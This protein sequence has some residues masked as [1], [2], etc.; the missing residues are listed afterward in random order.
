MLRVLTLDKQNHNY[1]AQVMP[2]AGQ[3]FVS[4]LFISPGNGHHVQSPSRAH[5]HSDTSPCHLLLLGAGAAAGPHGQVGTAP[6]HSS[7][8]FSTPS[9]LS[10]VRSEVPVPLHMEKVIFKLSGP[11]ITAYISTE[12]HGDLQVLNR[13]RLGCSTMSSTMG[14]ASSQHNMRSHQLSGDTHSLST[15]KAFLGTG[16]PKTQ[17]SFHLMTDTNLNLQPQVIFFPPIIIFLC[18]EGSTQNAAEPQDWKRK[19]QRHQHS[20]L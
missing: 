12:L 7:A 3:G 4:M 8:G 10:P 19:Q 2:H 20:R 1:S 6:K 15:L 11:T 18:L 14:S 17:T 9:A 16:K 13:V 5:R